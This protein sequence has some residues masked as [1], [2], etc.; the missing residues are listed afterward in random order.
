MD[1]FTKWVEVLP[2]PSQTAEEVA[3]VLIEQ[4]FSR[5][6]VPT[7]LH[8]DQGRNF[9]SVLMNRMLRRW[10]IFKTRTT[11]YHP[12][13]DG[14]V[15]RFNRTLKS[16]LSKMAFQCDEWDKAVPLVAMQY[17]AL[18]HDSS[19]FAPAELFIGRAMALPTDILF[20]PVEIVE[21]GTPVDYHTRLSM[22]LD[23]A[24]EVA[25]DRLNASWNR[26]S[27]GYRAS[28]KLEKLKQGDE[29]LVFQP[30]LTR[31]GS[32]KLASQWVGPCKITRVMS[33]WNF[34]VD[35]GGRRGKQVIHRDRLWLVPPNCR[36]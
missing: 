30:S 5:Y 16:A 14:M 29:V 36:G 35:R 9:E 15:E 21:P 32:A 19:G 6:G 23:S 10:G 18:K 17:R 31:L 33:E 27:H 11:P 24:Y 22:R 26:M 34:E 7:E 20:P 2:L 1:Y 4:V 8:S 13:S 12:A 3:D 28:P 25:R